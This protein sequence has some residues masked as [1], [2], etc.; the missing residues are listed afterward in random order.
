MRIEQLQ[1]YYDNDSTPCGAT[2]SGN[3]KYIDGEYNVNVYPNPFKSKVT[4]NGLDN[5]CSFSISDVSGRIVKYGEVK[6]PGN[7]IDLR[8]FGKGLY[9]LTLQSGSQSTCVKL[10]KK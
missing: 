6:S 4:I 2:W 7:E 5:E 3:S 8:E 1:W 10:V 9:I